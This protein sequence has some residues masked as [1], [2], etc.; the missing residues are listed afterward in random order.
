MS[1]RLCGILGSQPGWP[2]GQAVAPCA[3]LTGASRCA[4]KPFFQP[5]TPAYPGNA[6]A[7]PEGVVPPAEQS[8]SGIG[9]P[10]F[11]TVA[12]TMAQS[13]VQPVAEAHVAALGT[14][15]GW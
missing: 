12:G 13:G 5:T 3:R 7:F 14:F 10:P 4:R 9:F 11:A 6:Q 8:I 1:L 2:D 15:A